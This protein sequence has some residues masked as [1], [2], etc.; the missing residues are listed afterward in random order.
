V[1]SVFLQF[2]RKHL[3]ENLPLRARDKGRAKTRYIL[4]R[5]TAEV[6]RPAE[7]NDMLIGL[8]PPYRAAAYLINIEGLFSICEDEPGEQGLIGPWRPVSERFVV[9]AEDNWP[10]PGGCL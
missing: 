7:R 8:F 10:G 1:L 5:G 9:S 2:F 4:T 6:P 3:S